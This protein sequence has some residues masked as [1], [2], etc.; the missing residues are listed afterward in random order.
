MALMNEAMSKEDWERQ[1]KGLP[2]IKRKVTPRP[3]PKA[4]EI[5]HQV[6]LKGIKFERLIS[7]N[8]SNTRNK[9][10]MTFIGY[11]VVMEVKE[12]ATVKS[13]GGWVPE[14]EWMEFVRAHRSQINMAALQV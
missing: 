4:P 2:P 3:E 12:G 1:D 6:S 14:A 11:E 5:K 13:L 8:R 10:N 7:V 9:D